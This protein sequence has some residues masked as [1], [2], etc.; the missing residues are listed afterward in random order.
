MKNF[1]TFR[2]DS[3]SNIFLIIEEHSEK[4]PLIVHG[5]FRVIGNNYN[6][7]F[8]AYNSISDELCMHGYNELEEK[9]MLEYFQVD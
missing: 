5:I 3:K 2:L 6:D 7:A 1:T 8:V 9:V 4:L